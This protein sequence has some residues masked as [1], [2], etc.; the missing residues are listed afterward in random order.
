MHLINNDLAELLGSV[1]TPG[2]FYAAGVCA[3]HAPLL[4]VKGV[5]PI[6]LPLLA[7]QAEQLIAV[8]ERAPYGRGE[9]T[10]HDTQV[11]RSWQISTE[12]VRIEGSLWQAALQ[13]IVERRFLAAAIG[14]AFCDGDQ[15]L[16]LSGQQ[17]QRNGPDAFD[18]QQRRVHGAHA[19][20]V[21]VARRLH[22]AEQVGQFT[23]DE[24][25]GMALLDCDA[26]PNLSSAGR[27][28]TSDSGRSGSE[29][30]ASRA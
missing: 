19:G 14:R 30:P 9:E 2:D 25:H 29:S 26:W 27:C 20:H 13:S 24:M 28:R 23:V 6:A 8:A 1:K 11:R 17:G 18:S 5:G 15:L 22:R 3:M 12:S 16:G 7:A 10:L 4:R 21:E